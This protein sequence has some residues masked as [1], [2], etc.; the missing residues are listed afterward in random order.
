LSKNTAN[1]G[2]PGQRRAKGLGPVLR[3]RCARSGVRRPLH[4]VDLAVINFDETT[5]RNHLG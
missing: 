2:L 3:F 5:T 1:K 4:M